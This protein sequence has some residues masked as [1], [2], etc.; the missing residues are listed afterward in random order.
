MCGKL[1]LPEELDEG[2]VIR[3]FRAT[4][5]F[6]LTL[7]AESWTETIECTIVSTFALDTTRATIAIVIIVTIAIAIIITTGLI[8]RMTGNDGCHSK[9]TQSNKVID[10]HADV[11]W[12]S[13]RLHA[14]WFTITRIRS[15]SWRIQGTKHEVHM[16][17]A[18]FW[19]DLLRGFVW[20][21][22]VIWT[23]PHPYFI[24]VFFAHVSL[25][26]IWALGR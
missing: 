14:D 12:E 25:L 11:L 18:Y 10:F 8:S 4:V 2:L 21:K 16:R 13:E 22:F 20:S 15:W 23:H 6:I 9:T 1:R 5:A 24:L 19:V 17:D 7:F 3:G 26:W